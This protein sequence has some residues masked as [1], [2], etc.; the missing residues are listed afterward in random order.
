MVPLCPHLHGV[1]AVEELKAKQYLHP[2]LTERAGDQR[3][4][5]PSGSQ[6]QWG[7]EACPQ[8]P[9]GPETQPMHGQGV[10]A[11]TPCVV[12]AQLARK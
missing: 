11:A 9:P 2:R 6:R 10:P 3:H 1:C 5:L 12:A 7:F 8:Q 4:G